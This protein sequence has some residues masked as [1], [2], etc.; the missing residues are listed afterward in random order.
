[1]AEST[2]PEGGSTTT[3]TPSSRTAVPATGPSTESQT[4]LAQVPVEVPHT[5]TLPMGTVSN[6]AEPVTAIP[7]GTPIK[8]AA[9]PTVTQAEPAAAPVVTTAPT[10]MEIAAPAPLPR[11]GDEQLIRGTAEGA[12]Q[13]EELTGVK[14]EMP[15][16]PTSPEAQDA[17]RKIF[18]Q[19]LAQDQEAAEAIAARQ[20]AS[21]ERLAAAQQE[22]QPA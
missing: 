15:L 12:A 5:P 20:Q 10:Q 21:Q 18:E 11:P 6:F 3:A 2:P 19:Q 1:M 14:P 4:S 17:D 13:Q 16:D 22:Q 8:V 7:P 9:D